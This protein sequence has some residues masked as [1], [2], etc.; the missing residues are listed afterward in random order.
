MTNQ[1]QSTIKGSVSWCGEGIHTG[2]KNQIR[3][4]SAAP[5]QGIQFEVH[6]NNQVMRIPAHVD[7]VQ[8]SPLCTTLQMDG[9]QVHTVEHV[10]AA[11]YA[12]DITNLIIEIHGSEVPMGDGS[13]QPWVSLLCQSGI[14]P[15]GYL[16]K[17]IKMIS[18]MRVQDGDAWC[19]LIPSDSYEL[20]YDLHFDHPLLGD[21]HG[22]VQLTAHSFAHE[23][24]WARTF[25]FYKDLHMLRSQN[26]ALGA[27]LDNVLVFNA[28][29]VMN[30]DGMK[31]PD[32]PVR[33]KILDAVGDLS[34]MGMR[35]Q[36]HFRGHRSGH[37]LNHKL[38]KQV[39]HSPQTWS[40]C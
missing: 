14:Q 38:V 11:V 15:Q 27:S 16:A 29:G 2:E 24:A 32:E 18:P 1:M 9:V 34:L 7:H 23:I 39:L 17:C 26:K 36:G 35:I 21:S 13:A 40:W 10:L 25:G 5:N 31:A 28:Q 37:A 4:Q 3:F 20:S 22:H 33:H 19:E 8:E 30:M 12:L 6:Q